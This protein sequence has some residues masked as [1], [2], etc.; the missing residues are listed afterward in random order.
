MAAEL[1]EEEKIALI[2]NNVSAEVLVFAYEIIANPLKAKTRNDFWK[3]AFLRLQIADQV[4]LDTQQTLTVAK[5]KKMLD[6]AING[7]M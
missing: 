2:Q 4:A 5:R 6:R 3:D 1:T 7:W